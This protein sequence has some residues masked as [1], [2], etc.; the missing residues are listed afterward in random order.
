MICY[1]FPL[2]HEAGELLRRCTQKEQFSL[3]SLRCI[4]ANFRGRQILVALIGMGQARAGQNTE[5]I[6]QYFRP[7][8]FVLAGYGGALV[9]QMKVGQVALATNFSSSEVVPFLRLLSGFDFATFCT[10][11]ELADTPKKRDK[12]SDNKKRQVI[13]METATV[14]EIVQH[15]SIPFIAVRVISDEYDQV[16]PTAAL[17]AGFDSSRDQPKPLHLL[18]HLATHPGDYAPFKKFVSGLSIARKN[19]TKFLEQ[20]NDDLP[21]N[22]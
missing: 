10:A 12:Y 16:L 6:F 15:R 21:A 3:G 11:D 18:L 1:A 14:A 22:W 20:L 4:L 5:T 2:A 7:K 17:T 13:D 19:L 8:G 9:P